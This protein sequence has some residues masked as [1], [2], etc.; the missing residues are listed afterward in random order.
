MDILTPSERSKRMS[1]IRSKNTKP[2][3]AVRKLV[4][5]MGYRY[6]L[7]A[8]DLPGRPD[9]AFRSRKKAIFVHGCFWHLHKGCRNNRPP[10]SRQRYWKPKLERN[11]E[12][13][14]RVRRQLRRMGWASLV[15]WECE[16]AN[17]TRLAAKL[18]RFLG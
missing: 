14:K 3:I 10:K 16:T 17:P 13:D 4:H 8:D 11:A 9:L 2:E 1:L 5:G 15:I 7:Q 6:R 18:A 12:R